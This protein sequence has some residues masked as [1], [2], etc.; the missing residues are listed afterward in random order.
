MC[1]HCEATVRKCVTQ[2]PEVESADVS[3]ENGTAVLH[4]NGELTHLDE[5]KQ[6]IRDKGYEVE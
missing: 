2:F 5:I 1:P 3:H 6:A 4:L